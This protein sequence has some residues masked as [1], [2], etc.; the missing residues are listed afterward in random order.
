[1]PDAITIPAD[2][3]NRLRIAGDLLSNVA[4]NLVPHKGLPLSLRA[5]QSLDECRKDWEAA[6][7][8]VLGLQQTAAAGAVGGESP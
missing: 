5:C 2:A 6:R 8:A 7:D 4:F 3:F 1:M